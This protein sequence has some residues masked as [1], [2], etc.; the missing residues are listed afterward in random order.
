MRQPKM[1]LEYQCRCVLPMRS[2]TALPPRPEFL[3]SRS[4][5]ISKCRIGRDRPCWHAKAGR[6]EQHSELTLRI[7]LVVAL[8]FIKS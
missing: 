1:L 5:L 3:V 6:S 7:S 8:L 2:R 4:G